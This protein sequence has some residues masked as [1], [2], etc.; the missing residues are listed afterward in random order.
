LMQ[1]QFKKNVP[2]EF[3][4]VPLKLKMTQTSLSRRHLN[5]KLHTLSVFSAT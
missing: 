4:S 2:S 1:N 3:K 5:S